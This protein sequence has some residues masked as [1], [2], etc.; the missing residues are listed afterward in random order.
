VN[1]KT[2]ASGLSLLV[3]AP[4][5]PPA[6]GGMET[7]AAETARR[8][9]A[10]GHR[11]TV[12][13]RSG[14]G[15]APAGCVAAEPVL[16]RRFGTALGRIEERARATS[17]QAILLMN[18]AYAPIAQRFGPS[19]PPVVARTVGNDAYGAW[20][21]PR[22]PLRFLFWRLPHRD[23][24]SFGARL[25][26][27]DQERRVAAVV[28]GLACCEAILCNSRYSLERL[29]GLGLPAASLRL[30]VGGVDPEAYR[31]GAGPRPGGAP[32][33]GTAGRLKPIKG[34]ATALE[35]LSRL[36]RHG[37]KA[38]LLIAGTGPDEAPLRALTKSLGLGASVEFLGDLAASA[39]P[40]F[41]R[42]LDL[43]LQPSI[44][45]RH[46]S[47]GVLQAES[48][49][50]ALL[51]AQASGVPVIASRS[52]GIPDVVE[53]ERSGLLVPPGDAEQLAEAIGRLTADADARRRLADAARQRVLQRFSWEAVV[54]D[55]EAVIAAALRARLDS[56][57]GDEADRAGR[58]G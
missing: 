56:G 6:T 25:R 53:H 58:R 33:L 16:D 3:V 13:T 39:M 4:E 42:R 51:E 22:L 23:P 20:H 44:E 24:G 17:A 52:G 47:S 48:M 8:L 2:G 49:G 35:A 37:R 45:V 57:P 36:A 32:V 12:L 55:T 9:R 1:G 7:H 31:P 38:R 54:R 15:A 41:Y 40:D 18:A 21:G 46:E 11:V 43:Y 27:L 30:L 19:G 34:F 5:Y 14:Q 28:A 29:R 26:R 50:R 10:R